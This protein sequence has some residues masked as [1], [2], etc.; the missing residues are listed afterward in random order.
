M[1][2]LSIR[3][4]K[5]KSSISARAIPKAVRDAIHHIFLN[6]SEG[7]WLAGGTALAGFYAEHRKSDD[8]DL[9][10]VNENYHKAAVLAVKSLQKAGAVFSREMQTPRFYRTDVAWQN[11]KFTIDMVL[12]ENIHRIGNA[13]RSKDGAL[14]ADLNTLYSMKAACLVSRCSEKD[15]F[16]LDWIFF[17]AKEFDIADI[18]NRGA[19]IDTGL[20]VETLLYGIKSA[21]L[22]KDACHFLFPKSKITPEGAYKKILAV[23]KKLIEALL[24]Y[25]KSAPAPPDVGALAKK[26][27]FMKKIK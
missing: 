3:E 23:R 8:I 2:A 6:C 25:E 27:R 21:M 26:V 12:D 7:I 17:H 22:R 20:T 19:A 5:P 14:V 24:E 16:D 15:L 18:V 4:I 11:H 1:A 13:V 10:A 9:F